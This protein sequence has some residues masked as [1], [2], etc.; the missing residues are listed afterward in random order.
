MAQ[1]KIHSCLIRAILLFFS[2]VSRGFACEYSRHP[3]RFQLLKAELH[4]PTSKVQITDPK[5]LEPGLRAYVSVTKGSV[6]PGLRA[7]VGVTK[8]SVMPGR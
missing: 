4:L 1:R 6:V 3:S 8:G 2:N 5:T 7:Y